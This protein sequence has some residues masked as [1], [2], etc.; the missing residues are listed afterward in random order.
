[1]DEETRLT[2]HEHGGGVTIDIGCYEIQLALWVFG[3]VKPEQ[4]IAHGWKRKGTGW[5]RTVIGATAATYKASSSQIIFDYLLINYVC[6][7]VLTGVDDTV[8][9]LLKYPGNRMAQF[10]YS[11]SSALNCSAVISG[12]KGRIFV[13]DT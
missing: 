3:C 10:I 6:A 4:I 2:R 11:C 13:S 5:W 9:V 12:D 8:S 1:M 7:W